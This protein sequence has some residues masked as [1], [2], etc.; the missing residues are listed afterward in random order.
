MTIYEELFVKTIKY[1]NSLKVDYF[2]TGSTLLG[3]MR[4]GKL[5]KNDRE[6]DLAML[7]EDVTPELIEKFR[8]DNWF[9][10]EYQGREKHGLIILAPNTPVADNVV[11]KEASQGSF[12]KISDAKVT[13]TSYWQKKGVYYTEIAIDDCILTDK[14]DYNKSK[15]KTMICYGVKFKIPEDAKRHCKAV[16]GKDWMTPNP[17]W[18]WKHN[19]NYRRWEDLC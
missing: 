8:S 6:I 19:K 12:G 5:I 14:R 3:I 11:A 15:W 1:F 10:K 17:N 13:L 2:V 4:N 18:H 7:G 9:L 16:Y